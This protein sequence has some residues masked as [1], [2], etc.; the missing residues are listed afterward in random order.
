[1]APGPLALR[2]EQQA[3]ATTAGSHAW[4]KKTCD[5]LDAMLHGDEERGSSV[6]MAIAAA[7]FVPAWDVASVPRP[8]NGMAPLP[9]WIDESC[10]RDVWCVAPLSSRA[11]ELLDTLTLTLDDVS[12]ILGTYLRPLFQPSPRVRAE[13]GRAVPPNKVDAAAYPVW[14]EAGEPAWASTAPSPEG[15]R[16]HGCHNVLA[17][18]LSHIRARHAS[19]WESLWPQL[20]PPI[21]TWL[22][23]PAPSA[24]VR[25]ACV[26]RRLAQCAP[27]TLLQRTGIGAMLDD[28][29]AQRLPCMTEAVWGPMALASIVHARLALVAAQPHTERYD[30][31][32]TLFS[33]S[34][35][36]ALSYCA[37]ASASTMALVP[38]APTHLTTLS[39]ARLQQQLAGTALTLAPA[40]LDRLGEAA[41]RFW[42]AWMDW[43]V[44]WVDHAFAACEAPFPTRGAARP[45]TDLVDESVQ[46]MEATT[47]DAPSAPTAEAWTQAAHVLLHSVRAAV[48]AMHTLVDLACEATLSLDP[49]PAAAPGLDAWAV[50]L[51][52]ALSK[53]ALRL[54]ALAIEQ[55]HTLVTL[56]SQ[57]QKDIRALCA[58]LRSASLPSLMQQGRPTAS[59]G[60]CDT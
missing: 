19:A 60:S 17:W 54:E 26:A 5:I 58:R 40:M 56:G 51:V 53:C 28:T 9:T 43:C 2:L 50:R 22:D 20:L 45:L 57:L 46:R 25:G 47:S 52:V 39:S 35:L 14:D 32:C 27:P 49:L 11:D 31:L 7:K 37:P 48:H 15:H 55:P 36:T 29:L 34:V 30:K 38:Q 1:M 8:L 13:T 12:Y 3:A 33:Q 23:A 41:L 44:A 4:I 18:L 16:P 59:R 42:N 21:I 24:K 10:A 6:D